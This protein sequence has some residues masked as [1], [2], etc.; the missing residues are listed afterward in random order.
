LGTRQNRLNDLTGA[1]W[2][3]WTD[4]IYITNYPPDATHALRKKHGAMKPPELMADIIKFF[5]KQGEFI[6]DPFAGVGGTLLG[7]AL[8]RRESLG[9][10]LNPNWVAIYEKIKKEFVVEETRFGYRPAA[11]HRREEAREITGKMLTGDCLQLIAHLDDHSVD[12]VIT[13][14]P[15]GCQHSSSGFAGETNFNMYNPGA[16]RDFANAAN[17][18]EYFQLMASLGKA[19]YRVLKPKRYFI[20]L[21]GDRYRNGEFVPLGYQVAEVMRQTGFKLKGIKI[22][23]NKATQRPLKPY[24]VLSCFVPNITHQNILILQK[25]D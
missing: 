18:Q 19:A 7:A 4:T 16:A 17:F 13:D 2:L 12:A 20:L 11:E 10:E 14:P 22:W 1:E 15:Y 23:S 5:S 9:F 21:I 8:C 3:Y 25:P 6:L 24:A